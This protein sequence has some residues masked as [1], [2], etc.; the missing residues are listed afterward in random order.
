MLFKLKL[1]LKSWLVILIERLELGA[2]NT[3]TKKEI[4]PFIS[5]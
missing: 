4:S 3:Y 1:C 2:Q 5:N